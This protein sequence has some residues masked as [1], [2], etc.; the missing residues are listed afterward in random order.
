MLELTDFINRSS[1][2]KDGK[3]SM[4]GDESDP[5]EDEEDDMPVI[6]PTKL[7]EEDD[8]AWLTKSA[9]W[10]IF[11]PRIP[12]F[13]ANPVGSIIKLRFL[14]NFFFLFR[15][16]RNSTAEIRSYVAT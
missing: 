16:K 9:G 5:E 12:P 2:C 10:L 4:K 11:P 8:F 1:F 7:E 13:V 15:Q 14:L 6:S 3:T